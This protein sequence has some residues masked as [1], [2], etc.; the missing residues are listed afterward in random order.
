MTAP[1]AS[2]ARLRVRPAA[3]LLSEKVSKAI[4]F[5]LPDR[6]P[7]AEV[8]LSIDRF[9]DVMNSRLKHDGKT[10]RCG[11]GVHLVDQQKAL[12]DMESIAINSRVGSRKTLLPFQRG[13]LMSIRALPGLYSNLKDEFSIR[14]LLTSLLNQDC[15]ESFFT[16][17]W[18]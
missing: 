11:Y 1:K 17:S 8:I 5:L 12:D 4:T 15:S 18:G 13:I 14:Y 7:E 10:L 16:D 9:F 6:K 3:E 2:A